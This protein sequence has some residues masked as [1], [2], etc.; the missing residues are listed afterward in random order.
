MDWDNV[1]ES[2]KAHIKKNFDEM[3]AEM[4]KMDD[5]PR[6]RPQRTRKELVEFICW[7]LINKSLD[8]KYLWEE[9]GDGWRKITLEPVSGYAFDMWHGNGPGPNLEINTSPSI[10]PGNHMY[11]DNIQAVM[12]EESRCAYPPE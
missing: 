1:V 11:V 10:S 9:S 2:M 12:P 3:K 8:W 7:S 4:H 6:V 5:E